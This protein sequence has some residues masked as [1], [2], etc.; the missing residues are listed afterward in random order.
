[1][2]KRI[3]I[4]A[5]PFLIFFLLWEGYTA[6]HPEMSLAFPA[7]SAILKTFSQ[8]SD[9]LLLH[10]KVTLNEMC[11]GFLL[12]LTV[13]FP[14]AWT[15]YRWQTLRAILQPGFVLVQCMPMF[16][17]APLMVLAFGWGYTAIVVPT[18]LMIFFPLTMNIYQ[19][20]R[21][22][23]DDLKDDFKRH[24]A[25]TW[26]TF[27]KLEFPS[28]LPFIAAGFRISAAI[29]GIGAVAG[30][31]A[32]GQAGLGLLM[33]ESRRG[34]D[35]EMTFAALFCLFLSAFSFMAAFF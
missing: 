7:P 2:I 26:Q 27:S 14:C 24:Q 18:A 1:M 22:V 5:V 9:R 23:P 35:L 17:L 30:E 29:A 6:R 19:G 8:R 34:V 16:A 12:A 28:A 32:G 31:W 33:L 4:A 13:A 20:F 10:T 15:M 11:G 3:S 25:T 21:S